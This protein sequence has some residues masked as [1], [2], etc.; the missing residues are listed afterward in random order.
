MMYPVLCHYENGGYWCEFPDLEGCFS[1]GDTEEE[2]IKNAKQSLEGYLITLLE[3]GEEIPKARSIKDIKTDK[4]SFVSIIDADIT[5]ETKLIEK[6]ITLP[7]WL[8][9]KCEKLG[10]NFSQVLQDALLQKIL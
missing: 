9:E 6:N 8:N 5:C 7:K 10:I 2:I 4:N 3:N 1:Q